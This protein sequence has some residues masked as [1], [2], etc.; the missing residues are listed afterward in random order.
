MQFVRISG[1]EVGSDVFPKEQFYLIFDGKSM[2][3]I[4]KELHSL[5][6]QSK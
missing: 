2:L 3:M 5:H 4:G 6:I 1:I